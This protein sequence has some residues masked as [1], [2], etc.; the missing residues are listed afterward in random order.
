MGYN[1][2]SKKEVVFNRAGVSA[3]A[4]FLEFIM[5]ITKA[6]ILTRINERLQTSFTDD[7]ID[8]QIQEVLDDLSEEDLLVDTD[9][10]QSLVSGNLT[11]NEPTGFRAL[12]AIT[13]TIP[14]ATATRT[15]YSF[16][17]SNPDTIL[18]SSSSFLTDGFVAGQKITVSGSTSNN[19]NLEIDTITAGVITLISGNTLT[20]ESAGATITIMANG[21]EQ[22]PLR[23]LPGGHPQYRQLRHNDDTTGIPRWYSHFDGK[24]FLWRPPNQSFTAKIEYYKNHPQT[25][26]AIEFDD[27]Y[28]N[29]INAGA[30]NKIALE[31]GRTRMIN[32][33]LPIYEDAKRKRIEAMPRQPSIVGG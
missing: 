2:L 28:K 18:D 33:W 4:L 29:V 24:F 10:T 13:L 27:N 15:T 32:I 7:E 9:A 14:V 26:A 22:F 11:L 19:K 6:N 17:D 31:K 30:T 16:A 21:K 8:T 25:V 1:H 20:V 23:E 3:S 12:I 5:T